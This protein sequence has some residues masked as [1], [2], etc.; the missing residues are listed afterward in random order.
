MAG[1]LF[2]FPFVADYIVK[3]RK[4]NYRASFE[5][6]VEAIERI[7]VVP[8]NFTRNQMWYI[9]NFGLGLHVSTAP[10]SSLLPFEVF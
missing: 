4:K 2:R 1:P 8:V 9:E 7:N 3:A 6:A 10:L 5:N